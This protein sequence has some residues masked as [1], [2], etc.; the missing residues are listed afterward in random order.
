MSKEELVDRLLV[1]QAD[2]DA[3]RLKTGRLDQQDFLK[4]S[5]AMGI[6]A[7]ASIFIDDTPGLTIFD[8]RTKARRL[9][10]EHSIDLLL[11]DYLQL[12][13]GRTLD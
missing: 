5:D 10:I 9:M 7:D 1:S 3:W 13:H 12:A 11:V 4:L 2:I 8:M 6:L